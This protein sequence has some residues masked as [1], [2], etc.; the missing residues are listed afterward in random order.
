MHNSETG[1]VFVGEPPK[2]QHLRS[3]G[4]GPIHGSMGSLNSSLTQDPKFITFLHYESRANNEVIAYSKEPACAEVYGTAG[5]VFCENKNSNLQQLRSVDIQ[6]FRTSDN[7]LQSLCS[8][9]CH[10]AVVVFTKIVWFT[11]WRNS[12]MNNH[13]QLSVQASAIPFSC[14]NRSLGPLCVSISVAEIFALRVVRLI[15]MTLSLC[16]FLNWGIAQEPTPIQITSGSGD[17]VHPAFV[18][19]GTPF[20]NG[21]TEWLAFA[22]LDL[23]F[24]ITSICVATVAA[25]SIHWPASVCYVISDSLAYNDFPSIARVVNPMEDVLNDTRGMLVWQ[26]KV[27]NNDIYYSYYSGNSWSAP[28]ALAADPRD[29]QHPDVAAHDSSFGAVWEQEGKI[30]YSEFTGAG[31]SVP[32]RITP[33][34]D[35]ADHFPRMLYPYPG[36]DGAVPVVIWE[37]EKPADSTCA[38]MYSVRWD[39]TWSAPDTIVG[40][41]ITGRPNS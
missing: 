36:S 20:S 10:F 5:F 24:D 33:A 1:F 31:W 26:R 40:A 37:K 2:Q 18:S 32:E 22:R 11:F 27:D 41:A 17:D 35:S 12:N 19:S 8:D 28:Q 34:A 3:N 14:L 38:I 30:L 29:D 39:S 23:T 4:Y 21:T 15:L 9:C 25:D 6:D 7:A 13:R 16:S